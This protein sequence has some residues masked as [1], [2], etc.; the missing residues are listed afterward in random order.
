MFGYGG[1]DLVLGHNG[2]DTLDGGDGNDVVNGGAGNDIMTGGA[3]D[4]L[5]L[6]NW[7]VDTMTGG[8]GADSFVF[9]A[10]HSGSYEHLADTILDFSRAEGDLI[11]L[12]QID[13]IA[14]AGDDAFSFIGDAAFSGTAGELRFYATDTGLM[15]AGDTD[16]DGV[17]D[18]F[19][20]ADG[21]TDLTAADFVL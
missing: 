20:A 18:L 1:N 19:I 5:L 2:N 8:A 6:G 14:S 17:A 9:K 11:D 21:I 7:G 15:I 4:D 3:G 12:S 13:A 16:G 10:G